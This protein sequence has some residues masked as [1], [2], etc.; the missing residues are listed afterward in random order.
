M[1]NRQGDIKKNGKSKRARKEAESY[2]KSRHSYKRE[3][4]T[5][6]L[7]VQNNNTKST[8]ILKENKRSFFKILIS[9][10]YCLLMQA[11]SIFETENF[12][13]FSHKCKYAWKLSF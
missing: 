12:M 8:R 5:N 1:S 7:T 10:I 9:L 13:V 3:T 11:K 6:T 4:H 2:R